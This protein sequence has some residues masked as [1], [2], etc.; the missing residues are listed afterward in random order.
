MKTLTKYSV[1]IAISM[2]SMACNSQ[3]T[4]T[5]NY[6]NEPKPGN[7]PVIFGKGIVSVD[8][9]NTHAC[10]FSPDGSMLIFSRYP[11]GK[12]YTMTFSNDQWTNPTE[13][14]FTG[15][16]TSFSADGKKVFYYK[17]DGDI[18]Y[19]EKTENGWGNSISV[20]TAINTPGNT[21]DAIE[22]YPSVTGD[23]TLFFSRNGKWNEGQIFY[24]TYTNGKYDAPVNIGL[25]VNTGGALHA[26]VAPDKSYMIFNSPRT[27][28]YTGL[29]L[30][31]SFRNAD[32][33]WTNPQNLGS[34]INSGGDAI[35]C[36]TVTPDGKYMFFTKLVFS[37]NTGT[38]YW[39]STDFINSLKTQTSVEETKVSDI[40]I[41]PNPTTNRVSISFGKMME[42]E[43]DIEIYNLQGTQLF[44]KTFQNAPSATIDLTGHPTGIYMV[45]VIADGACFEEKI[46]KE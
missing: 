14:F 32:E 10:T 6:M 31:I 33:S 46:V 25:P 45:K 8:G 13:A 17:S 3:T 9:E 41:Y 37:S 23:G 20:G 5:C 4:F 21:T 35:L 44:S 27:E 26:F 38:V 7:T 24:S 43:S 28:S 22:Y 19:N 2:L 34:T 15:K 30:W 1:L 16:E 36:P 11:E 39:V 40:N 18:Y 29:D 12:S 42:R